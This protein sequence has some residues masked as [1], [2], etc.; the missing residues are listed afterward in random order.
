M[1]ETEFS[2]PSVEQLERELKKEQRRHGVGLFFR[3][4]L[5]FLLVAAVLAVIAVLLIFPVIRISGSSMAETL[6]DGDIVILLNDHAYE[7]GD[8]IGF[9][10]NNSIL[11]KRVIAVAGDWVDLSPG[12]DVYVNGI[13]LDEPYVSEKSVGDCNIKLPLQIPD[14]CCFVM[15][16]QR[17]VS[18][19]SRNTSLGCVSDD[20]VA[21]R[22]FLRI[23]PLEK[24]GA[25][26]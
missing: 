8:V 7:S 18:V 15:G 13:L 3:V 1:N 23:W 14:G 9:H 4:V 2:F 16:D 11:I 20:M 17:A 19:D 10:Y 25:F 5:V 6:E 22:L 26:N 21:G 24:I 12:G